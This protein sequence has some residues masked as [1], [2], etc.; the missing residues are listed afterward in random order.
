[1]NAPWEA[2][3]ETERDQ[4]E[5]GF[6]PTLRALYTS[7]KMVIATIFVD[8]EGE[9]IDYCT[10]VDP[11]DAKVTSA[12]LTLV[13]SEIRPHLV[14]LLAGETLDYMVFG[15]Q[16]DLM[17]RRVS[18]EYALVV[19]TAAAGL[20]DALMGRIEDTV[21]DIRREL[22]E[23]VPIWDVRQAPL[24]VGIRGS[25]SWD[26]APDMVTRGGKRI[27]VQDVIGRWR[28]GANLLGGELLCFRV[29]TDT[30]AELTLAYDAQQD[31]WFAW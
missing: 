6:T 19:M 11:Y 3:L 5:S 31:S 12:H 30:H 24:E 27:D 14:G 28:E 26:F 23:D 8:Y 25:V 20:D 29:H 10:G 21:T 16:R 2:D 4:V 22:D 1:M 17:L 13:L 9:C 7:S 15:S 18:D